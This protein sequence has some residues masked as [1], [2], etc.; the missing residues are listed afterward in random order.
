MSRPATRQRTTK[1]TEVFVSL[2]LDGPGQCNVGTGIGFLD[3]MLD[4]L[5][6]HTPIDLEVRATGGLRVDDHHLVEDVGIVLGQALAEALG[7][8]SGIRRFGSAAVPLDEALVFV[9]LDLSGRSYLAYGLEFDGRN[10]G[11]MEFALFEEFFR[12]FADNA[13]MNL[14]IRKLAGANGHHI[15][16]ACFKALARALGDA[17]SID[18]RRSGV[19]STK[20]TL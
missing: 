12:A 14:H 6:R 8:K 17:A 7:D 9:S 13:R 16:E 19:P 1:E 15:V 11:G 18:P 4:Q 20:G 5:A 2:D 10:V 3:H